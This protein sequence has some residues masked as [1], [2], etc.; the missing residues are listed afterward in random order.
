MTAPAPAPARRWSGWR[1]LWL[2]VPLLLLAVLI[3]PS[4]T[5]KRDHILTAMQRSLHRR[6]T[7][8]AVQ[9]VLLP[10]PGVELDNVRLAEDPNFGAEDMIVADQ[11]RATVQLAPLLRGRFVPSSLHLEGAHIN[12]V[13]NASGRWN[14]AS[15][16]DAGTPAS[17]SAAGAGTAASSTT[18]RALPYLE[19]SDS[20]V[21]FKLGNVKERFYLDD[22]SGSLAREATGW[23]LQAGFSPQRTDLALSNTGDVRLDGR[24]AAGP[25]G[26]T[27]RPFTATVHIANS[28]LQASSALLLG[29]D[30]GVDGILAADLT[31]QGDGRRFEVAG[32]YRAQSVRRWDLLPPPATVSGTFLGAYL[33][34]QD[35]FVLQAAG[36]PG[37]QRV[38]L[39]GDVEDALAHPR[40]ALTLTLTS[41]P[42]AALLPLARALKA[43]LP[44]N[45]NAGGALSGSAQLAWSVVAGLSG[46]GQLSVTPVTVT[47]ADARLQLPAM[48]LAWDGHQL[49]WAPVDASLR[50]AGRAPVSL[51]LSGNLDARG[52][53]LNVAGDAVDG[54]AAA[55][56]S[57][58]FAMPDFWPPALA[59]SAAVNLRVTAPWNRFREVVW[60]G[61]ARLHDAVFAPARGPRIALPEA[62]VEYRGGEA[63]LAQFTARIGADT[64]TGW[65]Q[66]PPPVPPFTTPGAPQPYR[67]A[68][69][70]D[71]LDFAALWPLL[72]SN[73]DLFSRLVGG[74]PS[75][76][77]RYVAA[78]TVHVNQLEWRGY[79]AAVDAT[80]TESRGGWRATTVDL[81]MA[82]GHFHGSGTLNAAGLAVQ[83]AATGLDLASLLLRS[84]YRGLI[85]GA[86]NANLRFSLPLPV[87]V[88]QLKASGDFQLRNGA[89]WRMPSETDGAPTLAFTRLQGR[90]TLAAGEAD[91]TAL[92]LTAAGPDAG[93]WSGNGKLQLG[94]EWSVDLSGPGGR[95]R[96]IAAPVPLQ[97]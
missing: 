17:G 38:R 63:P 19:W 8:D 74:E 87:G 29:H 49:T 59:G 51:R 90:F 39:A 36:D 21:D 93:H 50:A 97:P 25:N 80:L 48:H 10:W 68:L 95:H 43:G 84:R 1:R 2:L 33:P 28:Y 52:F 54:A 76:P 92:R 70:A 44:P 18:P 41:L 7:A 15:L 72:H 20:R 42:V 30:A 23:R 24:W 96:T 32:S 62:T 89:V 69:R 58:L 88:D 16:L 73:A 77:A 34:G 46:T 37:F 22:V 83:G 79:S 91:L 45:L 86:L 35:R 14:F 85:A 78:G 81:G 66:G 12:L 4:I 82:G 11:V 75:W 60:S 9:L 67:F 27:A 13:R 56:L 65:L 26:F 3:A 55:T 53:S 61:E 40:A 57:R 64:V 6:V 5:L 47:A 71:H 31:L 94:R